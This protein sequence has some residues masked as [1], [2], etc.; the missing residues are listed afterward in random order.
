MR[1]TAL[2]VYPRGFM[3][4]ATKDA[5][6]RTAKGGGFTVSQLYRAD[7]NQLEP[8]GSTNPEIDSLYQLM[9]TTPL[10]IG[11]IGFKEKVISE[12]LVAFGTDHLS[13]WVDYQ[14]KSPYLGDLHKEFITDTLCFIATGKR[15]MSLFTWIS[16]LD[17]KGRN[18]GKNL[19][20][21]EP[22]GL[23]TEYEKNMISSWFEG[24]GRL[25]P[26]IVDSINEWLMQDNGLN[27]LV[28]T[29]AILF[30]EFKDGSFKS[31]KIAS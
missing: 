12:A 7:S 30:G 31:N 5:P 28:V 13:S 23:V 2:R 16:L 15:R 19:S 27:D 1:E 3:G 24:H 10:V 20:V 26:H 11:D 17:D 4:S 25:K 9:S 6:M 21:K 18:D 22:R 8:L 29:L 14:N